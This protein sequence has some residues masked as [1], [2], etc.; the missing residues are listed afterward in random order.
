M[1]FK[2][3]IKTR[4][5]M[6]IIVL[7]VIAAI[8]AL[9]LWNQRAAG[10]QFVTGAVERGSIRHTVTATGTTEAVTTVQVGSQVSGTISALYADYNSRVRKG[11]VIAQLNPTIFKAQVESA[12]AN[13]V[14]ARAS[15]ADAEARKL[16][17]RSTIENQ[18]AGVSSAAANVE[19]LK[20]QRDDALN[21]LRRQEALAASQVISERDLE[22]ARA[23]YR[24]AEARYEQ[25][26]SQL[27]QARS[28]EKSATRSGLAQ[29]EAQVKQAQ[30]Q[31]L[32]TEAAVRQTEE[33]LRN[34][35]IYSPIDGVVVSRNVDVGQT[36]AAS[37]QA[38]TLFTIANDLT[39]MQVI[40]NIDQ[41]DIG[42]IN[43]DNRL[44]FT[45]DAFEDHTFAGTIRQIRL[46][47]QTVSNVVTYKVVIDVANPEQKLMPGMTA[48]L[49]LITAERSDVLKIPNAALRFTPQG[50]SPEKTEAAPREQPEGANES[51]DAAVLSGRTRTVW[52]LGDDK[53]PQPR[54]IKIGITDGIHTEVIEGEL[55]E[56]EQVIVSQKLKG[57]G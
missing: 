31:V 13:L 55:K 12:R 2:A 48:N 38:P 4:I 11:Q 26:A 9:T 28:L 7:G 44:S 53:S 8:I 5:L 33:N 18:Q 22:S 24:V 23:S 56:G 25:A 27:S 46:S 19:A 37:F 45:V 43:Q 1:T 40:A 35:T 36:I 50:A 54:K 20:V 52:V 14:A 39:H 34:A 30:A 3:G 10:E 21:A 51:P 49:I 41:A 17:A 47:P 57:E 6:I 42:V 32:Q 16:A 29:A 15:L